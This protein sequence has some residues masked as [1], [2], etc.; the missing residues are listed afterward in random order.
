MK[1]LSWAAVC[2][3]KAQRS[4]STGGGA[5]G[6]IL[7]TAAIFAPPAEPGPLGGSVDDSTLWGHGPEFGSHRDECP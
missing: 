3:D 2:P 6:W 7:G 1:P 5:V 4:P